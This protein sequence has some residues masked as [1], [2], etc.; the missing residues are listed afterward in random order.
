MNACTIVD[1][2]MLR[3]TMLVMLMVTV[4]AMVIVMVFYR[5]LCKTGVQLVEFTQLSPFTGRYPFAG[6]GSEALA[7]GHHDDISLKMGWP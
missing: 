3:A 2:E 7:R 6:S 1:D 5:G 4:M